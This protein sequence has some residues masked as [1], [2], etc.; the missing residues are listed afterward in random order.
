MR[1]GRKNAEPQLQG[2]CFQCAWAAMARWGLNMTGSFRNIDLRVFVMDRSP[3][4]V[5]WADPV[6]CP[7]KVAQLDEA[8]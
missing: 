6:P 7:T 5:K 1:N 2:K 8:G 3:V 4:I